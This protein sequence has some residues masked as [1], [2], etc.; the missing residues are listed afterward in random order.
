MDVLDTSM[1]LVYIARKIF[2]M[3]KTKILFV[4]LGNICRS[5]SAEA[6]MK[7]LVEKAGL[8]SFFEIDSAGIIGVHEGEN[9]DSRMMAHAARRG[10]Q[11]T[12]ISRPVNKHDF[13]YFD[14]IVGMD[15]QNIHDLKKLLP[16]NILSH[17]I[18]KMTDF[19]SDSKFSVVPDPYYGGADGFELVLDLLEDACFGLIRHLTEKK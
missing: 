17:K 8:S 9:A 19:A 16:H 3:T 7:A 14:L 12:S 15:D 5:P 1:G 11:L 10:Y 2:G 4:C 13:T 18:V 6:V